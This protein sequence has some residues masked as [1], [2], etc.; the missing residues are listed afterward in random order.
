MTDIASEAFPITQQ[1][2]ENRENWF[3][4]IASKVPHR[5]SQAVNVK[6]ME[7]QE[8]AQKS[9][10]L[11]KLR[12]QLATEKANSQREREL[13]EARK[14]A[15]IQYALKYRTKQLERKSGK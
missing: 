1:P 8:E 15:G 2:A 9:S 3:K 6:A 4:K 5:Q 13:R 11:R 14:V 12:M 10:A 7:Q